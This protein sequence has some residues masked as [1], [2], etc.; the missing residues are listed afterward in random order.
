GRAGRQGDPG[1]SR[2]YLSLEDPL[3]RIFAGDRV[4]AIMDRLRL[5]EGEPIEARM[6]SRSIESAQRKV[7]SRNFDIRKQ[8]LQYDDVANDQRKV[9]YAQRNEVLESSDVSE[10][11][12]GLRDATMVEIVRMYVPEESLEEQWDIQGLQNTLESDWHIEL[13]LTEMLEKDSSLAEDDIVERVVEKAREIYQSK[14]DLVG[15]DG[16]SSFERSVFLQSIDTNWRNHLS[17]LDHLRQGI[18]LRGYAQKDPKQEY[19]R[20]A[21]QLFSGMLDRIR[22]EVVRVLMTVRIQTP[23]QAQQPEPAQ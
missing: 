3:M 14:V 17:M 19:K 5:P 13:P 1:S 2:F 7:E 4:R 20:E 15:K 16:W 9:L 23:E 21:F 10:T 11:V 22:S 12:H 6:V 8:L 18:H